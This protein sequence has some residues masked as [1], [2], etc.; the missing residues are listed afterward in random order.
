MSVKELK[1]D[2]MIIRGARMTFDK[3]YE[4]YTIHGYIFIEPIYDL[5]WNLTKLAFAKHCC[6]ICTVNGSLTKPDFWIDIESSQK[7]K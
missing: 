6:A 1:S 4:S 7:K 5:R 3:I 2:L